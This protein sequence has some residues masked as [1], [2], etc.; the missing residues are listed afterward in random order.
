M[1][2]SYISQYVGSYL[3]FYMLEHNAYYI[4]SDN[5]AFSGQI[6]HFKLEYQTSYNP[7]LNNLE[8]L[9]CNL[10]LPLLL[11]LGIPWNSHVK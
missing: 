1:S 8:F 3:E 4:I 7:K 9:K 5:I 10:L 6:L 11:F 2:I